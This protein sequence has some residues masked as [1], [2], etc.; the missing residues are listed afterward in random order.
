MSRPTELNFKSPK[1]I[2]HNYYDVAVSQYIS[3][4]KIGNSRWKKAQF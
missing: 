1:E 4:F 3:K 2:H